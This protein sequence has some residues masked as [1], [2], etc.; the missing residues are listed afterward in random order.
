[1][2]PEGWILVKIKGS[3][4]NKYIAL[5]WNDDDSVYED[6][7]RKPYRYSNV[8]FSFELEYKEIEK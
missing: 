3:L 7:N 6:A 2:M 4:E 8:I 1:M 5:R